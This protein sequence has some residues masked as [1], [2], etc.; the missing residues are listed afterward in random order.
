M[1]RA[2]S[3][4]AEELATDPAL[5]ALDSPDVSG[6]VI[7]GSAMRSAAYAASILL[8]AASVPLIIRALGVVDYGYFVTITSLMTIVAGVTDAGLQNI[9]IREYAVREGEARTRM[10]RHLIGVRVCL[11]AVGVLLAVGF[12]LVA[13]YKSTL[14]LGAVLAGV[15]LI[16]QVLQASYVVSLVATL[17]LGAASV[18]DI[19]RQGAA[20]AF[21]V[22]L[23]VIGAKL[24]PFF[25]MTVVGGVVAVALAI[26]LTRGLV[27]LLPALDVRGWWSMLKDAIPY[28]AATAIGI[29]YFRVAIIIMSLVST[30][31][32]TGYFSAA[33]RITEVLAGIPYMLVMS[34]FPVLARAAQQNQE[35]L[36][37]SLQ[38]TFEV[39]LILGVGTMLAL[40][41]GAPFAI[42]VVAGRSFDPS[43]PAL[44]IQGAALI[45]TFLVATWGY[46][47]LS[48]SRFRALLIANGGALVL[49]IGLT[50][51]L[52]PSHG[53][54]GAAIA[55]MVTEICLALTYAVVIARVRPDLRVSLRIVPVVLLA[56]GAGAALGLL[57]GVPSVVGAVIAGVVYLLILWFTGVIPSEVRDALRRSPG[58][59]AGD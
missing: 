17:R 33:F 22:V 46:A 49:A 18:L 51:A 19:V 16:L 30:G 6:T 20:V 54:T 3:E 23:V 45:F 15:G 10:L 21:A 14:V 55:M 8:S 44:R 53:A 36:R 32:E 50:L 4:N 29:V 9:G 1:T 35:R 59:A 25:L 27:P 34:I 31:V 28:S 42:H 52:A 5:S 41:V 26:R 11:T 47:L 40:L 37:Y 12:T 24:L 58:A 7:R 39:A 38:R 48:L 13:G 2:L 57:T 56:A 43:I